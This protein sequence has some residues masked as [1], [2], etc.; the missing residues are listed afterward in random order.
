MLQVLDAGYESLKE[1]LKQFNETNWQ[2]IQTMYTEN[3]EFA[4]EASAAGFPAEYYIS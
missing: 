4:K 3:L 2:E 1:T